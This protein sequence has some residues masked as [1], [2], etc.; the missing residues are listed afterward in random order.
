MP[1]ET[2]V[3]IFRFRAVDKNSFEAIRTGKKR[4]ETRAATER[5]KNIQK[6]DMI[7][8]RCGALKFRK[9]ITRVQLF[10]SVPAMLR[11]YDV[12]AINPDARSVTALNT[13]YDSFP[14]YREKIRKVGLV[15]FELK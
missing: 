10:R 5:Y 6:G 1:A 15:A 13:M 8:C 4:V 9:R 3:R 11:V 14:R 7:E 2:T 12:H